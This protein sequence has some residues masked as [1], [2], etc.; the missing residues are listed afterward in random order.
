[1]LVTRDERAANGLK[2]ESNKRKIPSSHGLK[3]VKGH[4]SRER[5]VA[6]IR[7]R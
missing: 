4:G 6:G 2:I 3:V 7:T 5:P 1:M